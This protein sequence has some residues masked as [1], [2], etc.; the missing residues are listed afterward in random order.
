[1]EWLALTGLGAAIVGGACWLFWRPLRRWGG[2]VQAERARELFR[3]QRERLEHQ[4]FM[5]ASATGK[6]RGLR[7][8]ECLFEGP[9]EFARDRQSR[10]L[11]A[12]VPVTIRFTAVEG[13]DMEGLPAV[14]NVRNASA[15]FYLHRGQWLTA[16][17]AVFNMNPD[18]AL[19]HFQKQYEQL[20]PASTS[21]KR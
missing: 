21:T 11:I 10:Q 8:Q 16:G 4:F 13:G 15:I 12:L 7:W 5:A 17:K 2:E 9:A 1:M 19:R 6:P 14:G 18:E 3:L 20:H